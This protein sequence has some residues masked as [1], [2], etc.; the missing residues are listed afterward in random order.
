MQYNTFQFRH[1]DNNAKVDFSKQ[2]KFGRYFEGAET[3]PGN[4]R[5][6]DYEQ[7]KLQKNLSD[8]IAQET[9]FLKG[10]K[11]SYVFWGSEE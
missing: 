1:S 6:I 9:E 2:E 8:D 3:F 4:Q 10:V 5:R 7:Y 11:D